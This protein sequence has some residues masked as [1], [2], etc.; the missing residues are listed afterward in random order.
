MEFLVGLHSLWRW[1]LLIAFTVAMV[2][3]FLGWLRGGAWSST[4]KTLMTL[5]VTA[6]DVQFLLGLIVYV[7][8]KHWGNSAFIAYIHPLVMIVAL[9]VAHLVSIRVK[10]ERE[11]SGKFR[12]EALGLLLVLFLVTAAI[13]SYAWSRI[14]S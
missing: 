14:W 5:A 11:A 12:M 10:R 8:G 9:V 7:S 3:G 2:R 1:V 4:D 6:I 13:P